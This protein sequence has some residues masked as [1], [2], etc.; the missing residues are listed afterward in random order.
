MPDVIGTRRENVDEFVGQLE[1]VG[2]PMRAVYTRNPE[3]R[4]F[5]LQARKLSGAN[6]AARLT[7]QTRRYGR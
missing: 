2:L 6:I 3:G 1:R 5:L 4:K 7:K